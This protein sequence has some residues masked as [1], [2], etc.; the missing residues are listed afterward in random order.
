MSFF[1]PD[2]A[3]VMG[4]LLDEGKRPHYIMSTR[5]KVCLSNGMRLPVPCIC[6][7]VYMCIFVSVYMRV[8][9]RV[10]VPP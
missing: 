10:R 9:I 8:Y 6:A 7:Y 3:V 1:D 4:D 5:W 2:A